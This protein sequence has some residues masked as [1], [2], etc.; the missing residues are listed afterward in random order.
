M[1]IANYVEK[2]PPQSANTFQ[3]SFTVGLSVLLA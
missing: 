2:K 1:L 3:Y